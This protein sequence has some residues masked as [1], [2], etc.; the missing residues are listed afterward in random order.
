[1]KIVQIIPGVAG[2]FYCQNCMRDRE[3]VMELRARGHDVIMAPMYLPVFAEG[4][5]IAMDVPVFYGAVS[6]YLSQYLPWFGNLPQFI[7]RFINSRH[8]LKW[9]ASKA[10]TMRASGLEGMT[11]SVLSG[12]GGAQKEELDRLILWLKSEEK[13]D[14]V[15]L[16]NALLLGLAKR[17]KNEL[18]VPVVCT[19]QD[20]NSWI[21]S[22]DVFSAR[23]AWQIMAEKAADVAA[24]L[25]VSHYYSSLM[26]EQLG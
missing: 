23:K 3:F 25:P 2:A 22:M 15:H 14:I 21:N 11:L 9:V 13:P 6:V 17:I 5:D 19:L 18:G 7:K 10:G 16:S 26:Q 24:F 20:E 12:E 4:E 1:M 8:L